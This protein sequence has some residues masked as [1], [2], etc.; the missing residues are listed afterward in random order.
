MRDTQPWPQCE[1]LHRTVSDAA[2]G[3]RQEVQ[4]LE[5]PPSKSPPAQDE[6]LIALDKKL[7]A[8][9][10]M[11]KER[12]DKI[13]EQD[14]KVAAQDEK[15]AARMPLHSTKNGRPQSWGGLDGVFEATVDSQIDGLINQSRAVWEAQLESAKQHLDAMR[16]SSVIG[17]LPS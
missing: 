9:D 1:G 12:D 13:L 2:Q 14:E 6:K 16:R 3:R 15:I 17:P 10:K 7:N 4:G 8:K 5:P 11:I